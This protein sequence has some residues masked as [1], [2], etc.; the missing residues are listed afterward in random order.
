MKKVLFSSAW[1]TDKIIAASVKV[2]QTD[3]DLYEIDFYQCALAVNEDALQTIK[4]FHT[5]VFS[6]KSNRCRNGMAERTIKYIVQAPGDPDV[7]DLFKIK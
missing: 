3:V 2:T 5:K 1:T 6:D 4:V 7:D